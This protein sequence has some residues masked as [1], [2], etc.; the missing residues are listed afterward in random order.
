MRTE[1]TLSPA[2]IAARIRT[3]GGRLRRALLAQS[4]FVRWLAAGGGVALILA[5]GY[6]AT[7]PTPGKYLY[8]N[9]QF[10]EDDIVKI[11]RALD[12]QSIANR[13]EDRRIGVAADRLPEA[14]QILDKLGVDPRPISEIREDPLKTGFFESASETE[15]RKLV[16][17]EKILETMIQGLDGI[18][19]AVVLIH[20]SPTRSA[21]RSSATSTA[22]VRVDTERD[23]ALEQKTVQTILTIILGNNQDI[24]AD[25]VTVL[26]RKGRAYL[27]SG[28]PTVGAI[29]RTRAREEELREKVLEQLEW[30]KG[31]RVTVQLIPESPPP[32]IPEP[33]A[34][35]EEPPSVV[36]TIGV[37][38]GMDLGSET[39]PT[40]PAPQ[41][42]PPPPKPVVETLRARVWVGVPASY[43]TGVSSHRNPSAEDLQPLVKHNEELIHT[44]V[45]YVVPPA[46]AGETVVDTLPDPSGT[47]TTLEAPAVPENRS[48]PSW[49][50]LA[51]VSGAVVAMMLVVGFRVF[52]TRR[53]ARATVAEP[54]RGRYE[55]E[56]PGESRSAPSERVRELIRRNPEA[57][58]SVLNRWIGQGGHAE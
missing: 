34:V 41:P 35:I 18:T 3:Q 10:S 38:Q 29:S 37:N 13:V 20:R 12:A 24:K 36:S 30:I 32:P 51:G 6:V 16:A 58:A 44:A 53:P 25:A 49:W 43:Y 11:T 28:N 2:S 52:A 15:Q 26:D 55:R 46:E 22:F 40:T 7:S 8:N 9:K 47:K 57:G 45:K 14:T 33:V 23:R 48:A 1:K 5:V 56:D 19:S 4:V 39:K 54:D 31:V 27:H 17:D 50:I 21:F 42:P